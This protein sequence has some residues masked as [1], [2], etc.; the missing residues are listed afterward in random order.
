[1]NSAALWGR[2]MNTCKTCRWWKLTVERDDYDDNPTEVNGA[3]GNCRRYAPR[4]IIY[5]ELANEDAPNDVKWPLV[6][7]FDFCG[8]YATREQP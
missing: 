7:E 5:D 6:S 1:M 3:F 8:D 2:G 4:P